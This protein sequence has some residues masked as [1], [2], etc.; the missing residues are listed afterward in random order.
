MKTT[1]W[2]QLGSK[3]GVEKFD[4]DVIREDNPQN[5]KG[6]LAAML[7]KWLEITEDPMW[8]AVVD[9]LRAIE[10]IQLAK[11]L[12]IQFCPGMC[13]TTSI[14]LTFPEYTG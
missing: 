9:A 8:R 11:K 14:Q 1:K 5:T 6:A 7:K 10:E 3:L 12:E 2:H 13:T 4:L